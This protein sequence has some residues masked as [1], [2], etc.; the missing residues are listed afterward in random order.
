VA[1]KIFIPNCFFLEDILEFDILDVPYIFCFHRLHF[2]LLLLKFE[3]QEVERLKVHEIIWECLQRCSWLFGMYPSYKYICI[4]RVSAGLW[5]NLSWVLAN[6]KLPAASLKSPVASLQHMTFLERRPNSARSL[7]PP[8]MLD[9]TYSE[10]KSVFESLLA[11]CSSLSRT[12]VPQY[13]Q[14]FR[15]KFSVCCTMILSPPWSPAV[16]L[17]LSALNSACSIRIE[18]SMLHL[19]GAI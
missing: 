8:A 17:N 14:N 7:R 19:C 13:R 6:G 9:D 16:L 11:K 1:Y 10:F 2:P 3:F 18:F 5:S 4:R 12:T 15:N